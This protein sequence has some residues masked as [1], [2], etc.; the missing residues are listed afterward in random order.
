MQDSANRSVEPVATGTRSSQLSD[1]ERD[2]KAMEDADFVFVYV[3]RRKDGSALDADDRR[4]AG[5]VIPGQMNRRV[6]SDQ[7]RAIVIGSNFRMPPD[8]QQELSERFEF[9][10]RSPQTEPAR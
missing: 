6:V 2:L 1:L 9:E 3:I 8:A 5:T 4:F 7:G 10:D